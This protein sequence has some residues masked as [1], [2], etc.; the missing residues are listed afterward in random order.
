M[1]RLC[2]GL[3][4]LYLGL[5][6]A[7][8]QAGEYPAVLDWAGRLALGLPV[9]GVVE[10]VAVRPGAGVA[11]GEELLRL[12]PEVFE[13]RLAAARA[14]LRER[15]DDRAEAAREL[16]RARELY[17]RTVL[18]DHD[19]RLAEIGWRRAEAAWRKARAEQVAAAFELEHSRLRAPFDARVIAVRI[20]PG[21][22]VV[23]RDRAEPLLVLARRGRMLARAWL[24][25][26]ELVG[27]EPGQVVRVRLDGR[28][29]AGTLVTLGLEPDPGAAEPRYALEAEFEVADEAGLRP[30]LPAVL[31]LP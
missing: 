12:E 8:C 19:L 16:E 9:S 6:A 27:A 31:E 2:R 17:E 25:A 5:T 4:G 20:Q 24:P 23:S 30:G 15:E 29:Y 14:V 22:P 10:R 7:F 11:A 1:K 18:S 13:A 3:L 21:Q 28:R 26:R